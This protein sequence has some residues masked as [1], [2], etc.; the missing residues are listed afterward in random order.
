MLFAL[1]IG[2]VLEWYDYA[3]YGALAPV[4]ATVFF[5][6]YAPNTAILL[7][8][9]IFAMGFVC[10]PLG[11]LIVGHIGDKKGRKPALLLSVLLMVL[12]TLFIAVLPTYHQV[13][14]NVN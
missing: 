9:M 3:I 11:G 13:V 6:N 14:S 10:R 4:L 2:N 12:P 1:I 7:T 5:P 8:L